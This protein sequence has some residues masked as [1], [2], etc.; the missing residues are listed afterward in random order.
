VN[1]ARSLV[2]SVLS[3]ALAAFAFGCV[4]AP[5]RQLIGGGAGDPEGSGQGGSDTPTTT[6]PGTGGSPGTSGAGSS[7]GGSAATGGHVS[8]AFDVSLDDATP[9]CDLMADT[10]LH[11]TITPKNGFSGSVDMAAFDL[12][13]GVSANFDQTTLHMASAAKTVKLTLH[14]DNTV[15]VGDAPFS[16]T[17]HAGGA[18]KTASGTLTVNPSITVHIPADVLDLGGTSQDPF[19]TAY[20]PY[21]IVINANGNMVT[22]NFM[23]DDNV[24]HEIHSDSTFGHDPGLIPAHT[25]DTFVRHVPMGQYDFYLHDQGSSATPGQIVIQ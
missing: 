20:G 23:N 17:A 3:L 4:E 11:V 2:P 9:A 18:T 15:M 8:G 6:D 22:V 13:A 21:P 24:S 1:L 25:M 5:P 19:K 14:V 7:S 10:I 16:V 12:P